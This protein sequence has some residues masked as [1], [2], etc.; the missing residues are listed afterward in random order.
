LLYNDY[1]DFHIVK[2]P[3]ASCYPTNAFLSD[4]VEESAEEFLCCTMSALNF[5]GLKLP[6]RGAFQLMP[7]LVMTLKK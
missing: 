3:R 7:S 4:D 1:L 6:G 5:M 2:E